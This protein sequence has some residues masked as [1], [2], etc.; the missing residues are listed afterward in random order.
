MSEIPSDVF[1]AATALG[2]RVDGVSARR[3]ELLAI[4]WMMKLVP[5]VQVAIF[6]RLL[7]H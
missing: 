1:E 7:M 5:A 6:A 3:S 2:R 4:K